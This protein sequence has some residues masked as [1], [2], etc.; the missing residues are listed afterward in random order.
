MIKIGIICPS[1]IAFRRFL[2]ALQNDN[3]F[4]YI[5][6]AIAS[7]AEWFGDLL[8]KTALEQIVNQQNSERNRA[9]LFVD[10]FGGKIF[11]SYEEILFSNDIDA[12]YI[13]LPPALHYKWS[14]FA[15][16]MGKHV[17]VEKPATT[18]AKDTLDLISLAQLNQLAIHENY[19]FVFHNQLQILS[20]LIKKGEIGDV[21]LYRISFGF[22]RRSISDFRYNKELGGGALLDAG[23][24][25]IKYGNYLLGDT[26][27][28]VNA[29][30]NYIS[31]FDVDIFGTA[32][33]VNDEGLTAQLA[34]GM[35]N[36]YK[37]DIEIWGSK[38]S[39][40]SNR[41]LTA[42]VNFVPNYVIRKN[43]QQKEIKLPSDDA[44]L[45]SISY[46]KTCIIET[47]FRERNYLVL[48]RQADLVTQFKNLVK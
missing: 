22:P 21:R 12:I 16:K 10:N 14:K 28:I 17:F 7:P 24:Y 20:D 26:A 4:Q 47:S 42:P 3:E 45:K 36:D 9:K 8:S 41:I 32:T 38:G 31:D 35:D 48:Q 44:F 43:Q 25:T 39:I 27:K 1:E 40:T 18:N 13:P 6:V 19:M 11:D 5:G 33:M 15:L 46:F 23:G 2:P 34:F 30:L 29:N 37:C